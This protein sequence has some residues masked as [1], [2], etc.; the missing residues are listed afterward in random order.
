MKVKMFLRWEVDVVDLMVLLDE[1]MSE[2]RA[3]IWKMLIIQT[4]Y[5][6]DWQHPHNINQT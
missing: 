3:D 1:Y 2:N 5:I 6:N 4:L